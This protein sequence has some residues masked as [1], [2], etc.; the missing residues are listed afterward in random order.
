MHARWMIFD[1]DSSIVQRRRDVGVWISARV[2][3][4]EGF[5]GHRMSRRRKRGLESS[6]SPKP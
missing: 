5:D 1:D 4:L 2:A 6:M 3:D